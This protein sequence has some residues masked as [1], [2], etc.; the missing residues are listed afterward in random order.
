MK[1][2]IM[3]D[4]HDNMPNIAAAVKYFNE[5]GVAHVIH[6]GDFVAPFVY[7]A[8]KELKCPFTGVFGNNDGERLGLQKT[9]TPLGTLE[10]RLAKLDLGGKRIVVVHEGD[11]VEELAASGQYD[12]VVYGHSHTHDVR[13]VGGVLIVNPGET[14]G[15]VTGR[16][17]VVVLDLETGKLDTADL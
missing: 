3:S 4:S 11:F 8:L 10:P 15:W 12:L 16:S 13:E 5:A 1:I 14:C 7:R 17:T 6:A 2:G 9:L